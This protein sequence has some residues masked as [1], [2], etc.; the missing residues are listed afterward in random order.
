M[1]SGLSAE[2]FKKVLPE[3]LDVFF[4]KYGLCLADWKANQNDIDGR[5]RK[6]I[7]KYLDAYQN[8]EDKS[9][10]KDR[11]YENI[12]FAELFL[13]YAENRKGDI[14]LQILTDNGTT[15]ESGKTRIAV[16]EYI[17]EGLEWLM[18]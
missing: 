14:A 13:H 2:F 3:S 12:V 6:V 9:D 11:D 7:K 1:E 10:V 17:K 15:A 5:S 16:P 8:R 4:D 18:K